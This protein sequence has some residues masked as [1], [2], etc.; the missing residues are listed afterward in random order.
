MSRRRSRSAVASASSIDTESVDNDASS[1]THFF[2]AARQPRWLPAG[3][4]ISPISTSRRPSSSSSLR[5]RLSR[6][7]RKGRSRSIRDRY[8]A[9]DHHRLRHNEGQS[10]RIRAELFLRDVNALCS[11]MME[12]ERLHCSEEAYSCRSLGC[13]L[14]SSGPRSKTSRMATSDRGNV[15]GP[16]CPAGWKTTWFTSTVFLFP[17]FAVS[18]T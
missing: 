16:V 8:N 6:W 7:Q 9:T 1:T 13:H 10:C 17:D 2:F 11:V 15:I 12:C 5:R 14:R 3:E 18:G 4:S